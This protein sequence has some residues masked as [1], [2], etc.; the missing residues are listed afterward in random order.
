[1]LILFRGFGGQIP[2]LDLFVIS[3]SYY[4]EGFG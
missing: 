2:A 1:M 4:L 3:K